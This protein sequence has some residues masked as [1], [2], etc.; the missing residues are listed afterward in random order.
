MKQE[1]L[2]DALGKEIITMPSAFVQVH[3]IIV[4]DNELLS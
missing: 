4:T 2:E 1:D 3:L